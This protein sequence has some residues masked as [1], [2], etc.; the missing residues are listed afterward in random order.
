MINRAGDCAPA[1]RSL[2]EKDFSG[3]QVAWKAADG[4]EIEIFGNHSVASLMIFLVC[5]F[6]EVSFRDRAC[7]ISD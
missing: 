6:D 7:P 1:G 2:P 4:F 5:S 3:G